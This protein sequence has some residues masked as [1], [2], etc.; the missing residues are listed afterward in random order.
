MPQAVTHILLP[1][2]LISVIRDFYLSR[3]EKNS[4]PLHYVLIAGLGGVLPDI[5]IPISFLLNFMG[6]ENWYIH[7]TFLH[8]LFFPAI[9]L[10]LFL[11]FKPV[12]A[13]ARICNMGRHNLKLS[14]IFLML[15]IGILFHLL[16]DATFG[17][18]A[19]FLYPFS[20]VDYG[21]NLVSLLPSDLRGLFIPTLDGV[22]LVIYLVYLELKHKISDFV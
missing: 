22:L 19:F 2:L 1:I 20:L 3:K 5:D 13:K 17:E 10:V 16:L 15:A 21:I 14:T 8:S 11:A 9:F 6:F 4:F 7:K 18:K 12:K